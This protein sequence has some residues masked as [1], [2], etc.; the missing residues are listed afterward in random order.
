MKYIRTTNEEGEDEIFT[1]PDTVNHDCMAEA[2][3]LIRNQT[4]GNW[5]RV[6][7][8]PVSAG[9]IDAGGNCHGVSESLGLESLGDE[10]T[11]LLRNQ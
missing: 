11:E 6:L 3:E 1:F 9:F 4:Y 7:R 2:L 10:D 8:K 5:S